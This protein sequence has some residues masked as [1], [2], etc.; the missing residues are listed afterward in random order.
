MVAK[1]GPSLTKGQ[2]DKE[3]PYLDAVVKEAMRLTPV[4][5]GG[6]RVTDKTFIVDGKQIPKN[7]FILYSTYL[8]HANDPMTWKE[9]GTHMKLQDG[10]DPSRW[11]DKATKPTTEFMPWG[12][13][14]RF[15]PGS[16][17]AATEIRIFLAMLARKMKTFDLLTDIKTCKW[18]EG[19]VRTPNDGVVIS[20][21]VMMV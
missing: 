8:T 13:G 3:C 4:S 7:W 20:P 18:K 11:L 14:N 1:H 17:L 21:L 19:V 9:D 12:A 10:F 15:C 16:I 5:G 6:L 2:I